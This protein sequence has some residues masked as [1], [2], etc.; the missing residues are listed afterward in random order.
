MAVMVT[1]RLLRWWIVRWTPLPDCCPGCGGDVDFEKWM[2][3]FQTEL[4]KAR[5][6]VTQFR[7]EVGHCRDCKR[8]V[9]GRH[10]EHRGP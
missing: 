3:Q 2:E 10:P 1:G 8:R 6:V 9:Q 5:P 7:I 4:P